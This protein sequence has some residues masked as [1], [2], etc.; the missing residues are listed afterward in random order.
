MMQSRTK[1]SCCVLLAIFMTISCLCFA[2][3]SK[4]ILQTFTT[5][6]NLK[7]K[8]WQ[9]KVC[10]MYQGSWVQ[11]MSYPLYNSSAC[12]FIRKEFD[13]LKYDRPDHLYLQYRWQPNAC[14][15]PRFDGKHFLKKLKGKKIMFIGDSVSL[16]HFESLLCLLHAAVPDSIITEETN[17]SGSTVTFQDYGVSVKLFNSHYLVDIEQE[18]IGR[19]LKLDSLKDGNTWKDMDVLV[20]NTWL[21]WYRRGPKQP[22]DY[23]QEGETIIEDMDRMV[24]FRKGLTTWAKW[25]DSDVDTCKTKVI[26]QGISPSHYNGVEWGKPGVTNCGKET[27]P[28]SGS[29]YPGGSPLALQALEDVLNTIKK[30]VHLLNITTLSQLRKDGHPS[31]YNGFRGMDCTHWCVAGVLDA[32][33]ELLYTAIIS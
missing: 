1:R 19:V 27:Q 30:P 18:K 21:W 22:W 31:S 26:F 32:W 13:C 17:N 9:K 12:P 5:N 24:A 29:T 25:V 11:D 3:S 10:N 4:S 33:N 8:K 16:N 15:L 6:K 28:V 20:F 7:W 23:V 2:T 14:D